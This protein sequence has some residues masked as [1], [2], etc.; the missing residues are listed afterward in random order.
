[1]AYLLALIASVIESDA[2]LAARIAAGDEAALRRLFDRLSGRVRAIGL[3]VLGRGV[4]AD[5]VLQDCFVEVWQRAGE[6]D[7]ARGSIATWVT[8]IAHRRAVD[9]LRRRGTRPLGDASAADVDAIG[10]A[11]P[12]ADASEIQRRERVVRAL[13]ALQPEQRTAIELMYYGGLSQSESAT[14][15][16]VALGTLKSRVRA[17][18]N[19]LADLLDELEVGEP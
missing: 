13:A 19:R 1:M 7:P 9:R 5:D 4:E 3:R 2:T 10:D 16:G 14:Q 17:G 12:R 6:F 11:D 15:L 8:T 18:M